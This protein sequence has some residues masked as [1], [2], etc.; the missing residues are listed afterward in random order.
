METPKKDHLERAISGFER[1]III[2]LIC[3][4]IATVALS[5]LELG[6]ILF[7]E[8]MKPPVLFLNLRKLFDI[9]G[10]FFMVLIGLELIETIKGYL[11]HNRIRVE[12]V[13]LVAM[14]AVCR[15]VIILDINLLSPMMLLGI[16]ALIVALAGGYYLIRYSA[17]TGRKVESTRDEDFS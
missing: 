12:V 15:K 1:I 11:S 14:I 4:M 2:A 9:F 17:M 16:A 8:I 5:A 13:I 7:Q 6:Y 3:M 10:A